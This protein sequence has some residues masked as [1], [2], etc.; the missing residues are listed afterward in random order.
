MRS[1]LKIIICVGIALILAIGIGGYVLS[2]QKYAQAGIKN[3]PWITSLETGSEEA[4]IYQRARIARYGL[5]ALEK[6]EVIYYVATTDSDG[7][8]LEYE[9]DYRIEGGNLPARWWSITVYKDLYFIPNDI[10]RYSYSKTNIIWN[11]GDT[12]VIKLS[13]EKQ[14]G[15]WLPLGDK[16]P[17]RG[18]K[19]GEIYLMLRLYNPNPSVLENPDT[20]KLPQIIRER[21]K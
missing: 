15:N 7:K 18:D 20:I 16:E 19:K 8:P 3:G 13:A 10:N 5:W 6:S 9:C 21:C 1:A 12:W 17:L 2:P 11:E 4:S 14:E